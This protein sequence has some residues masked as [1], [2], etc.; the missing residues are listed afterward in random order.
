[1]D[2]PSYAMLDWRGAVAVTGAD[3]VPFLQGLVSNDVARVAPDRAIWTAFLT[4]QGKFLHEFMVVAAGDAL[5]LDCERARRADLVRRL[6]VYRLRSQATVAEA[7]AQVAVL[8]GPDLA[9][10]TGLDLAP[11]AARAVPG[12]VVYGDPRLPALGL[13][14]LLDPDGAAWLRGLGLAEAPTAAWDRLRIGLGVPDG[15]RDLPPEKAILLENGFDELHGLDW[16]K[17]CYLGQELTARTRYRGLVRKRLLPV[18]VDGPMPAP[19]TP[20][21]QAG[22][23][24]GTVHSG[25]AGMAL[26][27]L[28]LEALEDG[29]ALTAGAATLAPAIPD[30]VSLPARPSAG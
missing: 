11:G 20:V 22:R 16:D 14:A 12:G 9:E 6:K 24:V 8:F 2:R 7:E 25:A 28:R 1:M 15:S 23:E 17:G 26:A 13:R 19:E 5:L 10:A 18:A 30:W 21:T 27:R 3:A 4:A 29:G